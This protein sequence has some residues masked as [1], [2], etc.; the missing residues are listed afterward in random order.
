[1]LIDFVRGQQIAYYF[2]SRAITSSQFR[3]FL[4]NF[5]ICPESVGI[6]VPRSRRSENRRNAFSGVRAAPH[7]SHSRFSSSAILFL[8]TVAALEL[9]A[10]RDV[11]QAKPMW[12]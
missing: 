7:F 3:I 5:A 6:S 2:F 10:C 1:M 4:S 12:E 9:Q 8:V 11:E